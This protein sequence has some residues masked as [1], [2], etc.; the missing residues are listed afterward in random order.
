MQE[1]SGQLSI[2]QIAPLVILVAALGCASYWVVPLV[3]EK[4][5]KSEHTVD[6]GIAPCPGY[7]SIINP[8]TALDFYNSANVRYHIGDLKGT[9]EDCTTSLKLKPNNAEALFLRGCA[10]LDDDKKEEAFKDIDAAVKLD[11]NN[12]EYYFYRGRCHLVMDKT[13]LAIEDYTKSIALKNT[14]PAVYC[15]LA[16]VRGV[17]GDGRGAIADLNDAEKLDPK[18]AWIPFQRGNEKLALG[19]KQGALEDYNKALK[20]MPKYA[21]VVYNRGRLLCALGDRIAGHK[22]IDRAIEL[23]PKDAYAYRIRSQ[24][25]F[26]EGNEKMGKL[27]LEKAEQLEK[28]WDE[29][30][31]RSKKRKKKKRYELIK[32]PLVYKFC[33]DTL[34]QEQKIFGPAKVP[35]NRLYIYYRTGRSC[36]TTMV[37]EKR[38]VFVICMANDEHV[39]I[40]Y[41]SLV[42][43]LM[44]LLNTRIADPFIEGLCSMFV[45]HTDPP[46]QRKFKL[47][48][49]RYERGVVRLP[50]YAETYLMAKEL[51]K[52]LT[53]N[54]LSK[55]LQY[56]AYHTGSKDWVHID[57]DTW[58]KSLPEPKRSEARNIIARYSDVIEDHLPDDGA[59]GFARPAGTKRKDGK[60]ID[61]WG[62]DV[63]NPDGEDVEKEKK[64]STAE[65]L[66][67]Q[68]ERNLRWPNDNLRIVTPDEGDG[69]KEKPPQTRPAMPRQT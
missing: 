25:L 10:Y 69:I 52:K 39:D 47:W 9:R 43:E 35:V 20:V 48:S 27:D 13:P 57:T 46:N 17:R 4:V 49:K 2:R 36:Q 40:Y 3:A 6:G 59:Y 51:D 16:Y 1:Q 21:A 33:A 5:F 63:N 23:D 26:E 56:K 14:D 11:P 32:D 61:Q 45:E 34:A 53:L 64:K 65:K 41:Y 55:I 7:D 29:D 62:K 42:H 8:K 50:F 54:G 68:E 37:D 12:A 60:I 15:A 18:D 31:K 67:E 22:D 44:H 58:L 38:G 30:Q 19:D 28:E 24:V 66:R